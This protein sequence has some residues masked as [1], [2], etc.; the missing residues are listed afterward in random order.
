MKSSSRA[1]SLGADHTINYRRDPEW[2]GEVQRITGGRGVDVDVE[3]GGDGTLGRSLASKRPGCTVAIVGGV[4]GWSTAIEVLSFLMRAARVLGFF[5]GSRAMFE[6]LNRF[7]T[8]GK[9]S[10]DDRSKSSA[11]IRRARP[12][13]TWNRPT[14]SARS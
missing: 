7:V 11:S 4:G 5:V 8:T 13:L 1:R 10:A 3:V 12:T 6:D 2:Q 9:D 14:T